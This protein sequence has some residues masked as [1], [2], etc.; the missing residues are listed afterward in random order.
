M[1]TEIGRAQGLAPSRQDDAVDHVR[2]RLSTLEKCAL[3]G[4]MLG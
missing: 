4:R 1:T 2:R 3:D